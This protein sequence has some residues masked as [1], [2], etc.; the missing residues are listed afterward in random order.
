MASSSSKVDI[1][2]FDGTNDFGLWKMKMRAH[3]G[4]LGLMKALEGKLPETMEVEKKEE[5]LDKAYNTLILCLGDNV[6]REIVKC[7]SAAEVWLKLESL[8]MTK[9]L[10]SRLYL[11]ARFFTWKMVEG[12]EIQAHINDFNKLIMDL[13][14]IDITYDDE[15][16]ALVLLHSLPRS[17]DTF[18]EILQHGRETISLND[19]VGAIK[20]KEQKRKNDLGEHMGEGLL[21]EEDQTRMKQSKKERQG[22]NPG[23]ARKM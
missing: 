21:S 15:D 7:K 17:Y 10:S 13:E 18:V 3:L 1:E 9:S 2:K 19:V 11:K 12:K 22:P 20:A 14:N 23:V 4:N 6:L 5:A 8:Y 16:K